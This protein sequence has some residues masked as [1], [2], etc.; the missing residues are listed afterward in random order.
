MVFKKTSKN[1]ST[2]PRIVAQIDLIKMAKSGDKQANDEV[3]RRLGS[4]N[5]K[6]TDEDGQSQR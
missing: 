4:K 3:L 1:I 2:S 5:D 6:R